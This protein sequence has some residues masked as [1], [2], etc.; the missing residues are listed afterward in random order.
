MGSKTH[1]QIFFVVGRFV[2]VVGSCNFSIGHQSPAYFA[3]NLVVFVLDYFSSMY[4]L[5]IYLHHF[6]QIYYLY[7]VVLDLLRVLIV[8]LLVSLNHQDV[9]HLLLII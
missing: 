6:F 9:E 8:L 7:F 3:R 2:V 4:N 5:L 1:Q